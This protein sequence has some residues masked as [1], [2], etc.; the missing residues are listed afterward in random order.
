MSDDQRLQASDTENASSPSDDARHLPWSLKAV[1]FAY[2]VLG[3]LGLTETVLE[4][5]VFRRVCCDVV[6]PIALMG[7]RR[8]A[9]G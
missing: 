6:S 5:A 4:F 3:T 9:L 1:G 8:A 2:I 7:K